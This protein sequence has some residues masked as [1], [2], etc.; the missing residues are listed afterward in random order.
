MGN[1]AADA[2]GVFAMYTQ[3]TLA[4]RPTSTSGSPG[5]TGRIYY[6]TDTLHLYYDFGT[7]W[8]DIGPSSTA[9][10]DGS[11]T[12]GPAGLGVKIAAATITHDNVVA[13][14]IRGG[15]N[16]ISA[17]TVAAA[18]ISATLKPSG[19]AGSGTESLRALG[20]AAGTAAAGT[21][22]SQHSRTGADPLVL[23][24]FISSG[25][26]ASR[27]STSLVAGMVYTA[28]DVSGG[29]SYVYNGSSW[30]TMGAGASG[31]VAPAAHETTHL[32]GGTDAIDWTGTIHQAGTAASRPTAS[33]ANSGCLY[34]ATDTGALSRSN[35]SAWT[36]IA[37][38]GAVGTPNITYATTPPGSPNNGDIWIWVDSISNPSYQFQ[39]RYNSSET[40]YKWECIGGTSWIEGTTTVTA[41]RAGDYYCEIGYAGTSYG[42]N[43]NAQFSL[44]AGGITLAAWAGNEGGGTQNTAVSSIDKGKMVGL[45]ASTVLTPTNGGNVGVGR[46]YTR[47]QPVR[48]S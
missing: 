26:F 22:A 48:V 10:P 17:G 14:T 18:D 16:E 35:G 9:I 42:A 36:V 39:M 4:S 24:T 5:K 23:G 46:Q 8:A 33:S 7:G 6:G 43:S 32:P 28:T 30:I 29:T 15:G 31:G 45:A 21:H 40:T 38:P 13:G 12:G 37:G 20:T 3:G 2:D 1:L 19:G 41:P 44:T 25:T 27:P 34:F 47:I 11:I